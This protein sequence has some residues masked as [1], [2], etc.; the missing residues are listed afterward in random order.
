VTINQAGRDITAPRID[1]AVAKSFAA[2]GAAAA[3][4][5]VPRTW[6]MMT[7]VTPKE[8]T[9]PTVGTLDYWPCFSPDGKT[10]LFSRTL[11]GGRTWAL[12]RVP[13]DGGTAEPFAKL[14]V[15]ASRANWSVKS[16]RIVLMATRRMVRVVFG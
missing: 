14:P 4:P 3:K 2:P 5:R 11:D 12:F 8:I 7:G 15:S 10:V 13:A 1:E 16:G 6:T 9:T